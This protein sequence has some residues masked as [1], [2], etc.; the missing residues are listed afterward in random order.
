MEAEFVVMAAVRLI[1]S[2][3]VMALFRFGI[4]FVL[5]DNSTV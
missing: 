1:G 3:R 2:W 5:V 4:G